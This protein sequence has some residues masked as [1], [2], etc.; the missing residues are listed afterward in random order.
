MTSS[1]A[2]I[3]SRR[4][5]AR[6]SASF[7]FETQISTASR[8]SRGVSFSFFTDRW[9]RRSTR[10]LVL[11]SVASSTMLRI[12]IYEVSYPGR[13][14]GS[15]LGDALN[16]CLHVRWME[17]SPQLA[18]PLAGR[19]AKCH[20]VFAPCFAIRGSLH[21]GHR[22]PHAA[23]RETS[24]TRRR[25]PVARSI[26]NGTLYPLIRFSMPQLQICLPA[27]I[28]FCGLFSVIP[29]CAGLTVGSGCRPSTSSGCTG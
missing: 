17:P 29:A 13:T 4:I 19:C 27:K 8:S 22:Q 7:R 16:T 28:P 24:D 11:G 18:V 21:T 12:L 15:P 10:R 5:S 26:P 20:A 14:I 6:Y 23:P 3:A 2:D 25:S 9:S 1:R